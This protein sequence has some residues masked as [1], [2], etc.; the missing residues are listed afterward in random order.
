[1]T[2]AGNIVALHRKNSKNA[3]TLAD[4]AIELDKLHRSRIPN[5]INEG[6][7]LAEARSL[8]V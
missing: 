5:A 7:L 2:G 4:I 6:R 3:R 1:M 8:S